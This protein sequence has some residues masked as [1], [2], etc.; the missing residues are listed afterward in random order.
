M[1]FKVP[2]PIQHLFFFLRTSNTQLS[3][4]VFCCVF[5]INPKLSSKNILVPP[6]SK[7]VL[8]LNFHLHTYFTYIFWSAQSPARPMQKPQNYNAKPSSSLPI[9][10]TSS[11][12]ASSMV[13]DM[14]AAPKS[15]I[16]S[17]SHQP[18]E[19]FPFL[20]FREW[21]FH[22]FFFITK[23]SLQDVLVYSWNQSTGQAGARRSEVSRQPGSYTV[24]GQ[25]GLHGETPF[26]KVKGWDYSSEGEYYLCEPRSSIYIS[27][28]KSSFQTT[29]KRKVESHSKCTSCRHL[30]ID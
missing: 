25:S 11:L 2:Y 10:S 12:C 27:S 17:L 13:L 6:V 15:T 4:F 24:K 18:I 28:L 5:T 9:S 30:S 16:N 19:Y 23:H 22:C 29:N 1:D 8:P 26:L 21:I 20:P 14:D 7:G 3:S